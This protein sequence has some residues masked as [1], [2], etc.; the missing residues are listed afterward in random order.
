MQRNSAVV[1]TATIT[2]IGQTVAALNAL[3]Q[4]FTSAVVAAGLLTGL[5]VIDAPV[6][7]AATALFGIFYGFLAITARRELRRNGQ[8]IAEAL[9][10]QLKA[11]QEGLGAIR[12]VLLDG[13]QPTYLQIYQQADRP[14][15]QLQAKNVFLSAF[16]RYAFE[17]LGIVAI[18][19]LGGLLLLQR[20]RRCRYSSPG[21]L[22]LGTTLMPA[23]QQIYSGWAS[24]KGYNMN[25]GCWPSQA[26]LPPQVQVVIPP[27][28]R[29]SALRGA[30]SRG[31]E[32]RRCS[33]VWSWRSDGASAS[34]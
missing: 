17:A 31:P 22:A 1:I 28:V 34:A 19:L 11:L 14:Q 32:H 12:D 3:L 7:L 25:S 27:Y 13:S 18:A 9:S 21:C 30:L 20:Q 5:L 4:I 15:R 2:Q 33:G 8:K 6:A 23:L 10:L 24:L 16:P 26:P 29:E